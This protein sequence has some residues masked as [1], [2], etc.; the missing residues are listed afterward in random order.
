MDESVAGGAGSGSGAAVYCV[1]GCGG[2]VVTSF[3][4]L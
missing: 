1:A 4:S 2:A 3:I